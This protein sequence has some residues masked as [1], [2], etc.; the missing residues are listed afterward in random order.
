MIIEKNGNI[1][2][3]SEYDDKWVVKLKVGKL[4][5]AYDVSKDLCATADELRSYLLS[6]DI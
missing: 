6:H 4:S 1:Y 2:N 3:I 5:V